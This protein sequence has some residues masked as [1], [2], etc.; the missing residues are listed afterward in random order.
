MTYTQ[1]FGMGEGKVRVREL[2]GEGAKV[3]ML[4]EQ[5]AEMDPGV[6]ATIPVALFAV[7]SYIMSSYFIHRYKRS[8][9][10]APPL[11]ETA[12]TTLFG[13]LGGGL[14]M[15]FTGKAVQFNN[16]LFFYLVLP[17]I[18]FS[19]GYNLKRKRFFKY[20]GYILLFGLVGTFSTYAFYFL[21]WL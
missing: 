9:G 19:A 18:I 3:M 13:I 5:T 21:S 11:H 16:D 10:K 17:P 4:S 7:M 8:T 12:L 1:K 14:I 15:F 6:R 20:S 2:L